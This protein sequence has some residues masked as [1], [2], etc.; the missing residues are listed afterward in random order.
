MT[1]RETNIGTESRAPGIPQ[2]AV[3]KIRDTKMTTGL[4]VNR[5]P[6]RTGV[7]RLDSSKWSNRYQA[8]G[9]RACH[10]DVSK[11]SRPTAASSRTP[12]TGPKYGTKL[13]TATRIPHKAALGTPVKYRPA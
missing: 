12:A 10:K 8:G 7:M 5:R 9:S 1:L 4:S 6:S 2:S 13:N 11:V 3:Q